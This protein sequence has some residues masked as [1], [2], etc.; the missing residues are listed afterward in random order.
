[1]SIVT[2]LLFAL[3]RH[4]RQLGFSYGPPVAP[5]QLDEFERRY[6]VRLPTD[7]RAYFTT[8]NG[9]ELGKNGPMDSHLISFWHLSEL[10]PLHEERPAAPIPDGKSYFVFADYSI[11][12]HDYVIELAADARAPS[13]VMVAYDD[14]LIEVATSFTAFLERYL[15]GDGA[16][17]FPDPA[18]FRQH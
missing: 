9:S 13:S 8:L 10:C 17:L 7:L 16:V 1:M 3:E 12:V 18:A 14:V 11:G 15:V 6:G 2:T 4:W 5:A